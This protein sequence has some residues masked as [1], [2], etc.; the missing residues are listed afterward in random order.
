MHKYIIFLLL[1]TGC[2]NQG[3]IKTD[4]SIEKQKESGINFRLICLTDVVNIRSEPNIKS[5]VIAKINSGTILEVLKETNITELINDNLGTWFQITYNGNVG[6]VFGFYFDRITENSII[7]SPIFGYAAI[8]KEYKL[9][10]QFKYK[11]YEI[12]Y[13]KKIKET[14]EK[15]AIGEF[16]AKRIEVFDNNYLMIYDLSGKFHSE[17]WTGNYQIYNNNGITIF[18]NSDNISIYTSSSKNNLCVIKYSEIT[19]EYSIISKIMIINHEGIILNSSLP[20]F[21]KSNIDKRVFRSYNKNKGILTLGNSYSYNIINIDKVSFITNKID[22][23]LEELN[24]VDS[25]YIYNIE[26]DKSNIIFNIVLHYKDNTTRKIQ[27]QV[28][29]ND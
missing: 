27:R 12:E 9:I 29:Y 6:F 13:T 21:I 5:N 1:I 10:K 28:T 11:S 8:I 25:R 17:G 2:V 24:N 26:Y 19:G 16:S 20:N 7:N 14:G 15:I 3:N 4:I 22:Y 23:S 18:K